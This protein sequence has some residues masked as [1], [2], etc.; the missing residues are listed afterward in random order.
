MGGKESSF[1]PFLPFRFGALINIGAAY[2]KARGVSFSRFL[3]FFY[4]NLRCFS[5]SESLNNT[6]ADII[7][8]T[9]L[10]KNGPLIQK[11]EI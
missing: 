10:M 9:P 3:V 5:S 6:T 1:L 8:M 4:S 2:S 7:V 11:G